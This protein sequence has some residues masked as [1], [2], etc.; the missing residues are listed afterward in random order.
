M[1]TKQVIEVEGVVII[2]QIVCA[3]SIFDLKDI[4]CRAEYALSVN[5]CRD[6]L[7]R[8]RIALDDG[9]AVT[10]ICRSIRS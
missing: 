8:K 3:A 4:F 10:G 9:K 7:F 6:C 2:K 1:R 5:D